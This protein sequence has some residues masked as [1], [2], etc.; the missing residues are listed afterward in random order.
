MVLHFDPRPFYN[1]IEIVQFFRILLWQLGLD[2]FE[3]VLVA[4]G[5]EIPTL[6]LVD[7]PHRDRG[8]HIERA[9]VHCLLD[10]CTQN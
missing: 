5:C 10:A 6:T 4:R 9:C 2:I 8:V 3:A 1:P 7:V